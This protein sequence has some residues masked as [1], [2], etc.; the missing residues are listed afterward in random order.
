MIFFI[1]LRPY[2]FENPPNDLVQKF[3]GGERA[4]AGGAACAGAGA[5]AGQQ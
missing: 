3:G 2:G 1:L 4:A 5:G